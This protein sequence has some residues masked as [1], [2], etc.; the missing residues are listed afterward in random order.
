MWILVSFFATDG[1]RIALSG[2]QMDDVLQ[3]GDAAF[4]DLEEAKVTNR[5]ECKATSLPVVR[6]I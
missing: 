6:A 4:F 1:D 5:F 2:M 3:C